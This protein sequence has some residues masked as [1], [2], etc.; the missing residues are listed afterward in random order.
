MPMWNMYNVNVIVN[1]LYAMLEYC[2]T[3]LQFAV[4][5]Y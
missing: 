3:Y 4:N 5:Y 1:N 2:E